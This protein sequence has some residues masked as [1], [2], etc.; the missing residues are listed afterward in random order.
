MTRAHVYLALCILGTVAPNIAFAPWIVEHG[1]DISR[2]LE[3]LFV[4]RVSSA[5]AI[6]L[7]VTAVVLSLFMIWEGRRAG[8]RMVWLPILLTFSVG[9]SCGVPLFMFMRERRLGVTRRL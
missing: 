4:N 7:A 6:D 5:F 2:L 1:L 8:V 3:E 9:V